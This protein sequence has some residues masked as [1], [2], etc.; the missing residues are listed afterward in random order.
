MKDRTN[1]RLNFLIFIFLILTAGIICRLFFLQIKEYEKYKKLADTQHLKEMEIPAKRGRV[2]LSDGTTLIAENKGLVNVAVSPR[3]V[4]NP[5]ELA[6]KLS[7]ALGVSESEILEKI[8]DK[9]KV[10]VV[11]KNNVVLEK[12]QNI[13]G[14]AGVY[15]ESH[16]DRFYPL[17][18][19][20]SHVIGF[21]GFD[22]SGKKKVGQYGIEGFYQNELAGKNGFM[23]GV[24]DANQ[25]LIFSLKNEVQ[26]P[27]NGV[28]LVLTINPDIQTFI[29]AKLKETFEKYQP[30]NATFIVFSPKTGEILAMASLPNFDPNE[31][32]KEKDPKVFQ[33]PALLSFE[34]GSIFKPITAAAG[35]EEGVITP[36]TTYYDSG[37]VKIDNFEIKNSDLKAHGN[38]TMTNVIELSLNTGAVFIQQKL[39]R[40]KF[41][42]YVKKFGFGKKTG[43]DLFG[44][45]SGDIENI[46]HPRSNAKL[47][48]AANASFGQGISVTPIQILMAFS[49]IANQGKMVKPHI[50]KA[51][52]YPD[53]KKKIIE[54]QIVGE[55]ISPE[56]ASRVTAMMVSATKNGYS[57]KAGVDGYLIAGKTGTAEASWVYFGEQKPGYSGMNV[58]SFI[59][60]APAF[61]PEYILLLKMDAPKRGPRFSADSLAPVAREINLFLLNYFGIPPSK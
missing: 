35:I 50:V 25:N 8:K 33:N 42:E 29:E 57:K 12:T 51:I 60:F 18:R 37:A 49:A 53:G 47:I 7:L 9:N 41:V 40:E 48:E 61:N 52:I 19:M 27:V 28:D 20:V 26:E 55:P 2:F 14:L 36:Q 43:I 23:K 32:Y 38:Q 30:R 56:T 54:P 11:I 24:V 3:E 10:W 22:S 13:E 15:L 1:R 34:P 45:E 5:Q 17:G 44:E 31:Y 46:V 6:R 16:L 59:N 58:Q 21:Y 4:K 39:G